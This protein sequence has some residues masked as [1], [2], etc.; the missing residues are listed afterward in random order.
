MKKE[1]L[2]GLAPVWKIGGIAM[3]L[4]MLLSL[5]CATSFWKAYKLAPQE[6]DFNHNSEEK[7]HG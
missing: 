6:D 4:L 7:K 1:K 5:V 2:T 3:S